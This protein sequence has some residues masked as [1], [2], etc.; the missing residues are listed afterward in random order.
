MSQ[1]EIKTG[2][3]CK[4]IY[5]KDDIKRIIEVETLYIDGKYKLS[6]LA[7][8]SFESIGVDMTV[9]YSVHIAKILSDLGVRITSIQHIEKIGYDKISIVYNIEASEDT[10][11]SYPVCDY[12]ERM[13]Y[14][15]RYLTRTKQMNFIL[16][17][18]VKI[19][20]IIEEFKKGE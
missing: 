20:K 8:G 10:A 3:I 12:V 19:N 7:Q 2:V 15:T 16:E 11:L 17:S 6:V 14:N 18:K 9:F 4:Y 1:E 5:E 13:M